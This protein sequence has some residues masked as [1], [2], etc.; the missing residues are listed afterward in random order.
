MV[1]RGG[2]PLLLIYLWLAGSTITRSKRLTRAPD[3]ERS[4]LA[5]VV[6]TGTIVLLFMQII[7]PYF[8]LAG[9]P[10]IYWALLGSSEARCARATKS[11]PARRRR[12]GWSL[13]ALAPDSG[14]RVQDVTTAGRSRSS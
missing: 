13:L 2:I 12:N 7:T 8:V 3:F 9:P 4:L 6:F 11:P 10:H 5:N 1:V 14:E